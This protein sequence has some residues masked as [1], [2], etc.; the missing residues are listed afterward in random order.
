MEERLVV[1]GLNESERA[2][3]RYS[4]KMDRLI[5]RHGDFCEARAFDGRTP[6]TLSFGSKPFVVFGEGSTI[7]CVEDLFSAIRVGR[8]SAAVPLFGSVIPKDWVTLLTRITKHVILWLD[9]DKYGEAL[10]Q[11]RMLRLTGLTVDVVRT[12]LDPKHHSPEE[13]KEILGV[14]KGVDKQE[15]V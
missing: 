3:F 4:P 9:A 5:Y 8:V 13:V 7:T 6:K 12:E 2:L 1:M 15:K 11:A 10:K 14:F